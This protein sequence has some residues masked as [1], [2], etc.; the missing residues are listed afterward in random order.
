M[1][2]ER[3]DIWNDDDGEQEARRARRAE[4]NGKL[5]SFLTFFLALALVLAGSMLLAACLP[6]LLAAAPLAALR[7]LTGCGIL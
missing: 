2:D 5:K 6:E 7:G 3:K 4:K 1:S